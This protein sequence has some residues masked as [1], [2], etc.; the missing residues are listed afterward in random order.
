[1]VAYF[2]ISPWV[3]EPPGDVMVPYSN[4]MFGYV[5]FGSGLAVSIANPLRP[6]PVV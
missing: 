1:M 2:P 3:V 5:A 6:S 4:P